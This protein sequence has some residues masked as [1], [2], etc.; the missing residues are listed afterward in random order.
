MSMDLEPFLWMVLLMIP[1]DVE[2]SVFISVASCGWPISVSIVRMTVPVLV[3]KNT[4]P[5]L[6]SATE[7]TTCLR[8][9]EWYRSGALVS[10]GKGLLFFFPT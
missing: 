8:K 3:L 5:N 7:D 9:V 4:T 1:S 2:L 6:A 10:W